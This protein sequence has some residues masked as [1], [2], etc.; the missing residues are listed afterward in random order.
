MKALFQRVIWVLVQLLFQSVF[1]WII[2]VGSYHLS[3]GSGDVRW[4]DGLYGWRWFALA[5][6]ALLFGPVF[7]L[8]QVLH[9]LNV[10]QPMRL[11][12]LAFAV[13]VLIFLHV[14]MSNPNTVV[15]LFF[16]F[17]GILSLALPSLLQK[18]KMFR[19]ET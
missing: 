7:I 18:T 11:I 14:E 12:L 1:L 8:Q 13:L 4:L 3:E 5:W 15:L 6:A 16:S 17:A 2:I 9:A 19:S 10:R